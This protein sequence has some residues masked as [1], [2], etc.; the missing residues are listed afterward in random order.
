MRKQK[1][2][3]KR[4]KAAPKRATTKRKSNSERPRPK[5]DVAIPDHIS[6]DATYRRPVVAALLGG[7][8]RHK[9]NDMINDPALGLGPWLSLGGTKRDQALR[10]RK[11]LAYLQKIE[12][13]AQAKPERD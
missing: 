3:A 10:G 2:V 4:P 8:G 9:L 12:E 5:R 6:P 11:I 7:V 1:S 13:A